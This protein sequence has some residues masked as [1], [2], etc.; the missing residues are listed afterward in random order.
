MPQ[1]NKCWHYDNYKTIKRE[2]LTMFIAK[3]YEKDNS[4]FAVSYQWVNM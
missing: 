2:K 4:F 1:S 3:Q